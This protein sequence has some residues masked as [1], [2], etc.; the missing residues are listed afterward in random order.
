[1]PTE[2]TRFDGLMQ[3]PY[4]QDPKSKRWMLYAVVGAVLVVVVGGLW[5]MTRD[6]EPDQALSPE[7]TVVPNT[8]GSGPRETG[9]TTTA[10]EQNPGTGP[11]PEFDPSSSGF[12]YEEILEPADGDIEYRVLQT[13]VDGG[14]ATDDI[15]VMVVGYSPSLNRG[16]V[17]SD[18]V[19][20]PDETGSEVRAPGVTRRC[21]GFTDFG[22][23]SSSCWI[24]DDIVQGRPV[25]GGQELLL[26]IV[27]WADLP[28]NASVGVLTVNSEFLAWQRP[29]YGIVVFEYEAEVGD[30]IELTLLDATGKPLGVIDRTQTVSAEAEL[31]PITGYGDFGD[32]VLATVDWY[33]V[34]ELIVLCLNDQGINASVPARSSTSPDY[35]P[36]IAFAESQ[37]PEFDQVQAH[38]LLSRCRAGLNL[39]DAIP[40]DPQ[41]LYDFYQ[42]AHVCFA[43]LGYDTGPIPTFEQWI[44]QPL[45][46]RWDPTIL[47]LKR[48]DDIQGD[49]SEDSTDPYATCVVVQG[50][51]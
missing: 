40:S 49:R 42:D 44:K 26:D 22:G 10:L 20:P 18:E 29:R 30:V 28:D 7:T 41:D 27:S 35:V 16:V 17:R 8:D 6:A 9:S 14:Q 15:E 13:W 47:L 48:Y 3:S 50:T 45:G 11:E 2:P 32:A 23:T 5:L 36:G 37:E 1:M 43:D 39:P 34:Q 4:E 12:G 25:M 46:T 33:E 24:V 19:S 21:V 51:P 38:E 31:E